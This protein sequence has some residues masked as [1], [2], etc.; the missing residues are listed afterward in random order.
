MK[1]ETKL[2]VSRRFLLPLNADDTD[3][4]GIW[5][6]TAEISEC[7]NMSACLVLG[8]SLIAAV[9]LP[10]AIRNGREDISSRVRMD[11][12]V[13]YLKVGF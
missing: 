5:R 7:I 12:Q 4:E 1:V 6:R 11:H 9:Y 8:I 3:Y 13:L 10:E 2:L